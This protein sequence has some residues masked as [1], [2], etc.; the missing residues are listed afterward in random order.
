MYHWMWLCVI[1]GECD[2]S[3]CKWVWS[4]NESVSFDFCV[5]HVSGGIFVFG[6]WCSR[7]RGRVVVGAQ[8]D[9]RWFNEE[10][11]MSIRISVCK[12][13]SDIS[14]IY[15]TSNVELATID[16]Y[17][18]SMWPRYEKTTTSPLMMTMSTTFQLTTFSTTEHAI[19]YHCHWS[20]WTVNKSSSTLD[21]C[22]HWG[23]NGP[24]IICSCSSGSYCSVCEQALAVL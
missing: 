1:Q 5:C 11:S 24:H 15:G 13:I 20:R 21:F 14:A 17:C 23:W 6:L 10:Y 8:G 2:M 9:G 22:L 18:L 4:H 7:M 16:K 19:Y 12:L 3:V